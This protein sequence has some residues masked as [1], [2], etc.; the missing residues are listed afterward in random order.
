M[1][2]K[3]Q[4]GWGRPRVLEKPTITLPP[5]SIPQF[6]PQHESIIAET[7]SVVMDACCFEMDTMAMPCQRGRG[8]YPRREREGGCLNFPH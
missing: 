8:K 1:E 4:E 7:P 2:K 6:S 3:I 5:L